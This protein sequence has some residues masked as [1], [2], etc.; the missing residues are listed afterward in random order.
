LTVSSEP[1]RTGKT[2]QAPTAAPSSRAWNPPPTLAT[3]TAPSTQRSATPPI[4][5]SIAAAP[6]GLPSAAWAMAKAW[7][8]IGPESVTP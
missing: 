6:G 7:R 5:V 2:A 4:V 3:V 8:S 1:S